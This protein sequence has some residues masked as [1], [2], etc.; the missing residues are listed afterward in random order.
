MAS[1]LTEATVGMIITP[2]MSPAE[3][4]LKDSMPEK[5]LSLKSGVMN[6]RAKYP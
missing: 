1:S 5:R 4:A 6:V 2:I 3:I